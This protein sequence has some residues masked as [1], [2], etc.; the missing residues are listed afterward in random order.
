MAAYA[1]T[2]CG[3]PTGSVGRRCP[4]QQRSKDTPRARAH[5]TNWHRC[6]RCGPVTAL[7]LLAGLLGRLRSL[8][9]FAM[10]TLLRASVVRRLLSKYWAI[11]LFTQFGLACIWP[12]TLPSRMVL[13]FLF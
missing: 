5:M 2:V 13:Q 8:T 11:V 1:H 6:C 3:A 7:R 9:T 4:L 10:L 12:Q